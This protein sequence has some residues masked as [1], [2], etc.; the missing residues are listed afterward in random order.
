M[1]G[2]PSAADNDSD[3]T[4]LNSYGSYGDPEL[5]LMVPAYGRAKRARTMSLPKN[6]KMTTNPVGSK[7]SPMDFY[8]TRPGTSD[9][10]WTEEYPTWMSEAIENPETAEYAIIRRH[11]KS[12]D[13]RRKLCLHSIVV[14]SPLIKKVLGVV[15]EDYE[16]V[17]TSLDRLE[18]NSPFK[19]FVHRW[20]KFREV[21]EQEMDKETRQHVDILWETLEEDLKNTLDEKNDLIANGVITFELL[22]AIFEPGTLVFMQMGAQERVLIVE[23][24][25]YERGVLNLSAKYVEWDGI[26]FGMNSDHTVFPK[27]DGTTAIVGLP[28]YPMAYHPDLEGL[29]R[30]C[31]ARGKVWESFC[32]YSFMAYKGIGVTVRSDRY[33][34]DSRI[35]LDT[36]A[37]NSLNPN[38]GVQAYTIANGN[39]YVV[40]AGVEVTDGVLNSY[41]L[42]LAT[43]ELRGY[44]LKDKKWLILDLGG[45]EEIAWNDR[46][47]SSLILPNDTKEL[48]LAFAQS[49]IQTESAFD[50]VI[51][52]KGKGIIMLLSGPPGVGKTLTAEAVAETMR[53]P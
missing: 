1:A 32:K 15:F 12:S 50:D 48:V 26:R 31:I 4:S 41:Q 51:E 3:S 7:C 40:P 11:M 34:V 27:F 10:P 53:V 19:P 33:N 18:F 22:W 44:S 24:H 38:Y 29:Q 23:S 30:R 43:S 28:A 42:L 21:R 39:D 37:F 2:P 47:F 25:W 45:I 35:I 16:G 20:D 52:G 17:T 36:A 49:Q 13:M 5:H 9:D 14:Q 6:I 46:A 8:P